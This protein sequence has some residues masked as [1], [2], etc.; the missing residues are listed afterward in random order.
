M[1]KARVAMLLDN[2]LHP[3]PRVWREAITLS[4]LRY[5]V[6]IFCQQEKEL[7]DSEEREGVHIRRVFRYKLG[8]SVLVDKYLRAHFQLKEAL[9]REEPFDI[10][11]CH[12]TETWPLGYILSQEHQAKWIADAHEYFPDDLFRENYPDENKYQTAKLL[13]K[14][15]GEYI[16]HAD[17]VITVSEDIA[18]A[19]QTEFQ[20][21]CPVTTIYNTRY[22][23][24]VVTIDKKLLRQ[25]LGFTEHERVLVFAGFLRKDRGIPVLMELIGILPEN[26]KLLI[27]GDGHYAQDV[28]EAAR[29]NEKIVYAGMLPYQQMIEYVYMCDGYVNFRDVSLTK[30]IKNYRFQMPNKFFDAIFSDIPFFTYEGSSMDWYIHK[31]KVGRSFPVD[32]SLDEIAAVIQRDLSEGAYPEEKFKAAQEYF[33]W[34]SQTDKMSH[35]YE[36]LQK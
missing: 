7:P 5:D 18:H 6:T 16:R 15:R 2:P 33:S 8:T 23:T 30:D 25:K 31:Y 14:N 4:E 1:T 17:G 22:K 26:F 10:Y 3:D 27:I 34:K 11:H 29:I 12:D 13:I 21:P 35:L 24:D 36:S 20:L 32:Q 19:L 9:E 28:R